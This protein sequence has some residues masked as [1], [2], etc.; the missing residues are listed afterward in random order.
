MGMTFLQ[1]QQ[2]AQ[3]LGNYSDA[4]LT[5]MKIFIN[6]A[7][8]DLESRNEKWPWLRDTANLTTT[9]AV[10]TVA[11]PA[12]MKE[13]GQLMATTNAYNAPVW[14]D[15]PSFNPLGDD[16][17]YRSTDYIGVPI[18]YTISEGAFVF[19]PTPDA[20]YVYKHVY[21]AYSADL[22][23]DGDTSP[24]PDGHEDVL[25]YGALMHFAARDKDRDMMA[26]WQD[27]Y[28]GKINNLKTA[29]AFQ[30]NSVIK[31]VPMPGHYHGSFG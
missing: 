12:L 4:D 21:E 31:K 16:I 15:L 26:Y 25:I 27:M 9:P 24:I 23:A 8:R 5:N 11:V 13:H 22:S 6:M 14:V 7:K 17:S 20:A 3:V 1:M 18:F 30:Q 28:E 19:T 2:R 10:Q 29:V